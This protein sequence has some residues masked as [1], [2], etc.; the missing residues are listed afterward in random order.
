MK[1]QE[2]L[3]IAS[4]RIKQLES[5]L[6]DMKFRVTRWK[7]IAEGL[8]TETQQLKAAAEFHE[9]AADLWK[10]IAKSLQTETQQ[11]NAAA[12][13]HEEREIER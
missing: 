2:M 3:R 7:G 12:E 4:E 13:F 10:R 9:A 6:D 8:Q 5:D 11:L 1:N